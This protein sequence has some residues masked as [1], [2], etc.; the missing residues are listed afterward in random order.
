MSPQRPANGGVVVAGVDGARASRD[1]HVDVAVRA[2]VVQGAAGLQLTRAAE[3]A[4]ALVVGSSGHGAFAG[5]VL[6]SVSEYC[7]HHATCPVVVV[8][9]A[10]HRHLGS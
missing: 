1:A 4:S 6:G 7:I 9:D 8:R 5:M 2:E 10:G 3:H